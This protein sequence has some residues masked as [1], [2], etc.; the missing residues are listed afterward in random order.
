MVSIQSFEQIIRIIRQ[1]IIDQTELDGK[2][3]VNATSVRG[4]A[5]IKFLDEYQTVSP[6]LSNVFIVFEVLENSESD[7]NF[8]FEH[9]DESAD[10][11]VP[12]SFNL[13]IYG[14]QCHFLAQQLMVNLR[15]PNVATNLFNKG[16]WLT[17]ITSPIG[18]NE[19]INNTIWPRC[20]MSIHFTVQYNITKKYPT[21]Y[22]ASF[23][24]TII[25][26][27]NK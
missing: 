27:I 3:V 6:D 12:Y 7:Q 20:D 21:E 19:L 8:L 26:P 11:V 15:N 25:K 14:S 22:V 10:V 1:E 16:I 5:F 2:A 18:Q 24:D 4:P 23:T 9:D 17:E 13:K